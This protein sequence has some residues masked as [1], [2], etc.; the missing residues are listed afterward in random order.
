MKILEGK[1]ISK[2]MNKTATI[3]VVRLV[4]HPIYKKRM[5]KTKLYQVHDEGNHEVNEIV[6]FVACK[7]FSK[8]KKWMIVE[9]EAK[10]EKKLEKKTE[11][12]AATKKRET[13]KSV[14]K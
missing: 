10:A 2:K 4:A 6:S 12:K 14:K 5:K 8:S 11:K 9:K 1:I 3:E 13:K 7:P